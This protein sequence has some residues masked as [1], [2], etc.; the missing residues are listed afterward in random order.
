[1]RL[2]V[3]LEQAGVRAAV[4]GR[5]K[6]EH[7]LAVAALEEGSLTAAGVRGLRTLADEIAYRRR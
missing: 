1:M 2:T 6:G 4:E 7:D 3:A 5:I